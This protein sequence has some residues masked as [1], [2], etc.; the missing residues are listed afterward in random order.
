MGYYVQ[1]GSNHGKA[2]SIVAEHD[3]KIVSQEEAEVAFN[4]GKGVICVV[5]NGASY[6]TL[7]LP[8]SF[9]LQR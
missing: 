6:S 4:E 8:L 5:N 3:G 9:H 1:T 2:E 7:A